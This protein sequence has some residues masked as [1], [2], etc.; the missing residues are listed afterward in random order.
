MEKKEKVRM[1]SKTGIKFLGVLLMLMLGQILLCRAVSA[2]PAY[3]HVS[4]TITLYD[5]DGNEIST[6][7]IDADG[8]NTYN[9][10]KLNIYDNGTLKKTEPVDWY[11]FCIIGSVYSSSD[12]LCLQLGHTYTCELIVPDG[13]NAKLTKA[14][15]PLNHVTSC[16]IKNN[17]AV[18]VYN[19]AIKE[20]ATNGFGAYMDYY[21]LYGDNNSPR[22]TTIIAN[23]SDGPYDLFIGDSVILGAKPYFYGSLNYIEQTVK[24]IND[25]TLNYKSSSSKIVSVDKKGNVK[26]K[27]PGIATITISYPGSAKYTAAVKTVIFKVSPYGTYFTDYKI[28][29]A[30][31]AIKFSWEKDTTASAYQIQI[32]QDK[33]FTKICKT[34][35]IKKKYTSKTIT[36]L[37]NG[38]YYIRVRSYITSSNT[39]LYGGVFSYYKVKVKSNKITLSRNN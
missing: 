2:D 20:E 18:F 37:K 1:F 39:K 38:T 14:S 28:N 29:S 8:T 11:G 12:H 23:F 24:E 13:Y 19:E 32:A 10:L 9:K 16:Q 26:A 33:S 3:D 17:R 6:D 31:K 7:K 4:V 35:N 25:I 22:K 30:K 27:K 5:D 15:G 34:Y 21:Y 36:G